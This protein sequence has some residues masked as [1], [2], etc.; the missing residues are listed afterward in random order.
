MADYKNYFPLLRNGGIMAFHDI[1]Q[2]EEGGGYKVWNEIKHLY[3]HKEILKSPRKEKGI[4]VILKQ[5]KK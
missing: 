3:K 4:G 1:A 2:N 5:W